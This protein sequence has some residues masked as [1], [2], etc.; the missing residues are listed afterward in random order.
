MIKAAAIVFAVST[1]VGS[2][3]AADP[4]PPQVVVDFTAE[5]AAIV[6]GGETKLYYELTLT[7]V[8][9]FRYTLQSITARGGDSTATFDGVALQRIVAP[10]GKRPD[11]PD[12]K[13]LVIDG[14]H[15]AIVYLEL[16]LGHNSKPA[17]LTHELRMTDEHGASHVVSLGSEPV[18]DDP[19]IIVAPPLRGDWIAGDSANN[20]MDAAH[21]RAALVE[22]A[23]LWLA[24]RYA[25]DWV[26]IRKVK[27][28]YSTFEGPESRNESYICYGQPIY[29]VAEGTVAGAS[30]G[31]P[32]N[33]P[34]SGK[35][36]VP[37]SFDNAAG[38]HVVVEIGPGRF[39]LYAHMKPGSV[40]VK[41]GQHVKAGDILGDVGNTGS[42]TE[43][44]LHMHIDDHPS[45]LGGNSVP[46][47]FTSGLASGPIQA[48]VYGSQ[49][50]KFG[51]I[52]PQKPF[53]NDYPGN[54]ALV[55]FQ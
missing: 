46:Y 37:I 53:K 16:D 36:A 12:P 49:T 20:G 2:A 15:G 35:F 45:F 17:T 3:L 40:H 39:V 13:S 7:N 43:P 11:K 44:H 4:H 41:P 32:D 42:S 30:D 24:Q 26:Q 51:P 31:I 34:H 28:E 38:N 8:S 1:F 19:P 6:Q 55:S 54:N 48:N 10:Y 22:D 52:G 9:P 47:G 23:H 21:R 14:G 50:I 25:I 33:V 5:P 29:S 27:G 18:S